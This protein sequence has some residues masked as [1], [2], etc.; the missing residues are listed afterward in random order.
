M[1]EMRRKPCICWSNVALRYRRSPHV[2]GRNQFEHSAALSATSD[3]PCAAPS[4]ASRVSPQR[5]AH[6]VT[7]FSVTPA[8][9]QLGEDALERP[10]RLVV[11]MHP[12]R[13]CT[14]HWQLSPKTASCAP[15]SGAYGWLQPSNTSLL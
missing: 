4:A 15:A 9:G 6:C 13:Q 5:R 7:I 14:Q 11:V 3:R 1:C 10:A 2:R 8:A 12:R